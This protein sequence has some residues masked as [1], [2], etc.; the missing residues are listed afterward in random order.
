MHYV[1][2]GVL[3]KDQ[4]VWRIGA[5]HIVTSRIGQH[6][7][8]NVDQRFPYAVDCPPV[9][10]ISRVHRKENPSMVECLPIEKLT[11]YRP[12]FVVTLLLGIEVVEEDRS[13]L[14]LLTPILD[15]NA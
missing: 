7:L 13:L 11:P 9:C 2:L 3:V 10:I 15:D 14:R 6:I 4:G 8:E 1:F 12:F 5:S